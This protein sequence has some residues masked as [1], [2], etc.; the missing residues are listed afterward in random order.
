M[1]GYN[2]LSL[3]NSGYIYQVYN[4]GIRQFGHGLDLTGGI[5]S[6][7]SE[8]KALIKKIYS[9]IRQSNFCFF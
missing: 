5:G 4:H 9:T 3:P 7:W 2:F 1:S 8:L 6:V